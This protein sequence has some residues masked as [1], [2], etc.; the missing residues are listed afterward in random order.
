MDGPPSPGLRAPSSGHR[1][2]N[3]WAIAFPQMWRCK[4]IFTQQVVSLRGSAKFTISI[5]IPSTAS[6]VL[7]FPM[8]AE[9]SVIPGLREVKK[10]KGSVQTRPRRSTAAR[11][12]Y[13]VVRTT[14]PAARRPSAVAVE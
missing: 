8:T 5:S 9:A 1:R 6:T 10:M 7:S 3:P 13:Q 11:Y 14:R 2:A 12:Q 4:P